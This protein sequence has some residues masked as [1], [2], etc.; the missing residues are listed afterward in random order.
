[1]ADQ[2]NNPTNPDMQSYTAG[3]QTPGIGPV[4]NQ[5]MD[6]FMDMMPSRQNQLQQRA[7]QSYME[8]LE[9]LRS[10][11][12]QGLAPSASG[13]AGAQNRLNQVRGN[14]NAARAQMP[15]AINPEDY[16]NQRN[17]GM[18]S[19]AAPPVGSGSTSDAELRAYQ[20][21]VQSGQMSPADA[22]SAATGLQNPFNQMPT[23]GGA[24]G[25]LSAPN[26]ASNQD[27]QKSMPLA[28]FLKNL[29]N[30]GASQ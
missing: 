21:A 16:F 7:Y 19:T 8:A 29:F 2:Y 10:Q 18:G 15:P 17:A 13:A 28:S 20:D 22:A 27:V 12:A 23:P 5:E 1:M 4:K 6:Q 30:K 25:G 3:P 26:A 9:R 24:L 14:M 11:E